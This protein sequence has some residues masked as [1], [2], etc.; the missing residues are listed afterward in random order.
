MFSDLIYFTSKIKK[1]PLNSHSPLLTIYLS[2]R[3]EKKIELSFLV[4]KFQNWEIRRIEFN[5]SA[6]SGTDGLQGS[7]AGA[8]FFFFPSRYLPI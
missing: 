1:K 8:F 6:M 5:A 4:F 3:N 7:Q 2:S